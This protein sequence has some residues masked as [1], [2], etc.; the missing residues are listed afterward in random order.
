[1]KP[2]RAG[3]L[4]ALLFCTA[5]T[6]ASG[7]STEDSADMTAEETARLS[8]EQGRRFFNEGQFE[9]AAI[10]LERAYELRPS[11]KI[12]Y[13]LG[14]AECENENYER[15]LDAFNSYLEQVERDEDP[16]QVDEVK[17]EVK[18]LSVLV[19]TVMIETEVEG[20]KV[21]I[22]HETRASTPLTQPIVVSVG[23]HDIRV[24]SEGRVIL[25]EV[26]R[27]A[28]GEEVVLKAVSPGMPQQTASTSNEQDSKPGDAVM[29]PAASPPE[30]E[31]GSRVWTWV[32]LGVAVAAAAGAGVTGAL[33]LSGEK[34]IRDECEGGVCL[35][36]GFEEDRSRVEGLA[37]TTDVLIGV[38][39]AA[40]VTGVVLFF[41]EGRREDSEGVAVGPGMIPGGAGAF[42]FG[43]F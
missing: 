1:M 21:K 33:A 25:H 26:R 41:T 39:A 31:R 5:A 12:L 29:E 15:A 14:W 32:S 34:S 42:V 38:S 13:Y 37:L 28:G 7:Q 18:R 2:F 16:A 11:Y 8:F 30:L 35:Q 22:D 10:A 3:V 19:G 6:R 20:A 40:A 17:K 4:V 27:I 43:R 9:K 36:T 23:K 24:I